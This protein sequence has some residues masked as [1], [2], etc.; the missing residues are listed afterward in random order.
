MLRL[1]RQNAET[2]RAGLAWEQDEENKLIGL[3]LGGS[4]LS[5]IAKEL[6]R[7]EGSIRTR[8]LTIVCGKIDSGEEDASSAYN[9]YKVSSEE[10]DEFRERK[11]RNEERQQ[12]LQNR[13]NKKPVRTLGSGANDDVIRH[14]QDI[15]NDLNLL[16][17]HLKVV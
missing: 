6:Q 4:A 17:R 11:R 13:K 2:A 12:K 16:K 15:K 1:Q 9:K 5:D 8:L 7:T 3:V 10:L 14:L